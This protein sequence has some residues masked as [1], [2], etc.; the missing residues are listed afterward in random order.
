MEVITE[1]EKGLKFKSIFEIEDVHYRRIKKK[2][3][4]GRLNSRNYNGKFEGLMNV[5]PKRNMV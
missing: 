3:L 4:M 5:T 1:D 2:R